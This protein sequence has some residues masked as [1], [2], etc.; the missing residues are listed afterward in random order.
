M[1][2]CR[3]CGEHFDIPNEVHER[4]GFT[5]GLYETIY[6]CPYCKID[7]MEEVE[8]HDYLEDEDDEM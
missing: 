7:D 8:E 2:R 6:V 5:Y 4:H 1:Y 3:N